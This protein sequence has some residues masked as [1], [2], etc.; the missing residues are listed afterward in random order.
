MLIGLRFCFKKWPMPLGD[1]GHFC[2]E[3]VMAFVLEEVPSSMVMRNFLQIIFRN[4][5]TASI[6]VK[7]ILYYIIFR[8]SFL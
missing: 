5:Y 7:E 2:V 8:N 3:R 4:R 6:F 1:S